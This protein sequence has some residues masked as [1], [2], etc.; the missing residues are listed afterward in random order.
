MTTSQIAKRKSQNRK[1]LEFKKAVKVEM[2]L[3]AGGTENL[4]CEGCGADLKNKRFDYD[5]TVEI[6]ELPSDLREEFKKHGVPA[7]YGKVLGY[8]CC[9][10]QKTSE[11]RGE[12]A[13]CERIIEKTARA[14][15]SDYPMPFGRK[16]DLK[17]RMNGDIVDRHTGEV[18]WSKQRVTG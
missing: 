3:R 17:K 18:V 12:R 10:Q 7:E 4:R 14:T 9:H 2:F 13:H 5:H 6:W 8:S 1:G 11:K 15:E 16:S